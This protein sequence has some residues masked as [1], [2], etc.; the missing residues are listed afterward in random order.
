MPTLVAAYHGILRCR[1]CYVRM[2]ECSCAD[3]QPKPEHWSVCIDCI[4]KDMPCRL[5]GVG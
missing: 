1:A 2:D 3:D 4:G 5:Y